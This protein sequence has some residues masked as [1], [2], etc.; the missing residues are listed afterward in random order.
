MDVD[1]MDSGMME[2]DD[3]MRRMNGMWM[4]IGDH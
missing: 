1:A 3:E 4:M 2:Y